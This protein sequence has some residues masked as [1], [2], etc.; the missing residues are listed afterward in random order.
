MVMPYSE[1]IPR[2]EWTIVVLLAVLGVVLGTAVGVPENKSIMA[3]MEEEIDD[4]P[5]RRTMNYDVHPRRQKQ[6]TA[7]VALQSNGETWMQEE[8]LPG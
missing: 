2:I 8:G 3:G 1:M 7:V 6:S 4:P 5:D